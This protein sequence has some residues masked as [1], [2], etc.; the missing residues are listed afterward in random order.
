MNLLNNRAIISS[1]PQNDYKKWLSE[2]HG[3]I[4]GTRYWGIYYSKDEQEKIDHALKI[5]GLKT[6]IFSE[7]ALKLTEYGIKNEHILRDFLEQYL[8]MRIYEIGVVRMD[9]DSIF[10]CSV[11]GVLE[12]GE[13]VEFKTTGKET[14]SQVA[15]DG[16]EI[17]INYRWQ[18]NHNM[19]VTGARKC[20]YLS[21]SYTSNL[22]YYKC[23]NFD[24]QLWENDMKP[25]VIEFYNSYVRPIYD[26]HSRT[27][28]K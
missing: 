24:E 28:R 19:A 7:E 20:H 16:S 27:L 25:K 11:D 21:Y 14:P 1:T 15:S 26:L 22:F 6:D 8:G 12:N 17:P 3:L 23:F 2:R 18:M 10:A 13:I 4:T 5:C 9:S